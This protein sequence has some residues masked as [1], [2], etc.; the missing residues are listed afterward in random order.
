MNQ[1]KQL[2]QITKCHLDQNGKRVGKKSGIHGT[3]FLCTDRDIKSTR[4]FKNQLGAF[5]SV[6]SDIVTMGDDLAERK[7]IHLRRLTHNLISYNAHILQ[8]MYS[9]VSQ[10]NL[11][12]NGREQVGALSKALKS[13]PN[14]SAISMLRILKNTNLSKSEFSIFEKLYDSNPSLEIYAHK[15]HKVLV[16][17]FNSFMYDFI[18]KKYV[19]ISIH[20][21]PN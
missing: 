4:L 15:I 16:L 17:V 10:D 12:G 9:I 21:K 5:N 14:E 19:S 1:C 20:V 11:V 2:T 13:N 18:Q 8:D 3:V 7:A 6:L